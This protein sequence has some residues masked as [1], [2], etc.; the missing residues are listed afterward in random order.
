MEI[1]GDLA[2]SLFVVSTSQV[3]G[4]DDPLGAPQRG[5]SVRRSE[6]V[7]R[8]KKREYE[9]AEPDGEPAYA[10]APAVPGG[11]RKKP[12]KVVVRADRET[13]AR[14]MPPPS[15][16]LHASN[17][18]APSPRVSQR[19]FARPATPSQPTQ[20]LEPL[21]LPGSQLSQAQEE[22][23]RESG[24]GVETMEDFEAM[25]ED[26]GV[27]VEFP[28]SQAVPSA[29]ASGDNDVHMEDEERD[30]LDQEQEDGQGDAR[31]G[32]FGLFDDD[33]EFTQM[34][35]TQEDRS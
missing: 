35:A 21:F 16:P 3:H 14:S 23:L 6:S 13:A 1:E 9:S 19:D 30:E 26:E 18:F 8:G 34:G 22:V 32:S 29:G 4:T 12:Q 7:Q 20:R 25:L 24:L 17:P 33:D 27:E 11:A 31:E 28:P 5:E 15:L 10:P 2:A